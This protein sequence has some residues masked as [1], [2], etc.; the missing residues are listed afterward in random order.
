MYT[1]LDSNRFSWILLGLI[2]MFILDWWW[3]N[4]YAV[5]VLDNE[6]KCRYPIRSKHVK[7]PCILVKNT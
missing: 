6:R 5:Y 2:A 3:E 7:T 4:F 1:L